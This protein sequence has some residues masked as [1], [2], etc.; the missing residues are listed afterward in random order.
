[1]KKINIVA[2]ACCNHQGDFDLALKMIKMAKLCGSDYVKF[3]KRNC[4][5][6]VPKKIQNLPHPCAANSFG[7]TYLKHRQAMEFSIEQHIELKK[8]CEEIGI[9]YA[10]S[11]WD[12]DSADE[13][14]SL[15]PDFIKIPSA[16]NYDF[17]LLD[18]VFNNY[19]KKIHISFGMIKKNEIKNLIAYLSDKKDRT[20]AY[21]T[22]SGYP[23]KFKELYLLEINNLKNNFNE[24]GYSGHNL[25]IAVDVAAATLGCEWIE[26]HFT[27]DRTAKG[28][29]NAASLEPS[30]LSKLVRDTKAVVES[31]QYKNIDLTDDEKNNREKLKND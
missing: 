26:R 17:T 21:W 31:L 24:I 10:C 22:T 2:E 7:E 1:M 20:V 27:L 19:N 11:V 13:I 3:Q 18:H 25:G 14:M 28:T 9:K 5:K 30:G 8:Y 12:L 29:D 6:A 4:I 23:V 16:C 15:N